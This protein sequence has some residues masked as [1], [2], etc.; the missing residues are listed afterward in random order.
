MSLKPEPEVEGAGL[1]VRGELGDS[2]KPICA[3]T[4][5]WLHPRL[6]PVAL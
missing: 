3:R 1:W 5:E 6:R 4:L 2:L